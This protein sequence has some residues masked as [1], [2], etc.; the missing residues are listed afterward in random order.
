M[1]PVPKSI[2]SYSSL[3]KQVC[4]T[5]SIISR[6]SLFSIIFIFIISSATA[7]NDI[8]KD[9][10]VSTYLHIKGELINSGK[11]KD[12]LIAFALNNID[13]IGNSNWK[14][15]EITEFEKERD[16]YFIKADI[17]AYV[18]DNSSLMWC[19]SIF[20]RTSGNKTDTIRSKYGGLKLSKIKL[21]LNS[22]PE[23]AES[24]LV[25]NRIWIEKFANTH[26]DKDDAELQKF[27]VNTSSTNTYAYVDQT[28]FVVI[29]KLNDQYKKVIHF[30]K[31]A[32]VEAEQAVW[33]KF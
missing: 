33:I 22:T 14:S 19:T 11:S 2:G 30:T 27:R 17:P 7:Q 31:P 20:I 6:G 26:W 21:L 32:S 8:R 24:Y 5:S 23:G 16:G 4:R 15:G 3:V 13:L 28:V 25:P 9:S 10:T 12:S 29:F 1:D 18:P